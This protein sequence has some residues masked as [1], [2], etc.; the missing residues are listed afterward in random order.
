MMMWWDKSGAPIAD[1][2]AW[3]RLFEDRSYQR[4]ARTVLGDGRLVSTVWTGI[5]QSYGSSPAPLIFETMAFPFEGSAVDLLC[6]HWS[7]ETAAIAGHDQIV[8]ALRDEWSVER[9][10]AEIAPGHL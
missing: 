2:L 10:E 1:V 6:A 3:A 5:D 4:V 8:A 7:T 9:I